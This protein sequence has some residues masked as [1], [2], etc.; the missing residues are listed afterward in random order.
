MHYSMCYNQSG[1]L[2]AHR[3]R[4]RA[5]HAAMRAMLDP[6]NP[7]AARVKQRRVS[8]ATEE[9]AA[10]LQ[11]DA[12]SQ[13]VLSTDRYTSFINCKGKVNALTSII[14]QCKRCKTK[15]NLSSCLETTTANI[16]FKP[17]ALALVMNYSD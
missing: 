9:R 16:L 6:S 5:R 2:S 13:Q 1:R 11:Q 7:I 4:D 8:E 14:G 10:R 17:L 15:M 12:L 3:Q